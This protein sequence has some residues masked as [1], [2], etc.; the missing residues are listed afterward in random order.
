M[1][2]K[3]FE[4]WKQINTKRIY[5]NKAEKQEAKLELAEM[6][7]KIIPIKKGEEKEI[8]IEINAIYQYE[9]PVI[10]GSKI[11]NIIVKRKE[12]IIE[13]IDITLAK[14]IEKKSTISYLIELISTLPNYKLIK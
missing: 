3:E 11:G 5:I 8:T 1:V 12:E 9:A 2:K 14:T 10:E 6:K 7:R 4:N 13:T